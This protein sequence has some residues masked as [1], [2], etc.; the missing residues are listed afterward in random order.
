M[1]RFLVGF[2]AVFGFISLLVTIALGIG[3]WVLAGKLGEL[4]PFDTAG[5][6]PSKNAVVVVDLRSPPLDGPEQDRVTA[7]LADGPQLTLQ[8]TLD[9]IGWAGQDANVAGMALRLS[10]DAMDLA[11]A[12][13]LQRAI[14][15]FR[16][17]GK[18]V[19]AHASSFGEFGPGTISYF[20][21]SAADSIAV[22]E[23][24]S[25]GVTGVYAS[26]PFAADALSLLS[27]RADVGRRGQYKTAPEMATES[28]MGPAHRE[29][30]ES[31]TGDLF[32]QITASIAANRHLD[33]Q[34]LLALIDRAPLSADEA[35]EGGLIDD[36]VAWQ[37]LPRLL[38]PMN[39]AR[40]NLIDLAD[41]HAW[42]AG[43]R[44][45]PD[46]QAAL[47]Y[48]SGTVIEGDADNG[49][50]GAGGQMGA[51]TI[52]SA[53]TEA[54]N[55]DEFAG[56]ILRVDSGGGSASASEVIAKAVEYAAYQGKPLV[57]SMGSVAASG[58]YWLAAPATAIVAEGGTLT[59]SI[60]VFAG[61]IVTGELWER[62]GVNW[63]SVQQG[64]NAGMFSSQQ[65]F[66][67]DERARLNRFLD[68]IY[69]DFIDRVAEGRNLPR[70]QVEQIAQGRV[71]TGA[72]AL[73][74]G[75]VDRIG[76]L[77]TA[78]EELALALNLP[79]GE[80]LAAV[81]FP[82][83]R[84]LFDRALSLARSGSR[85][86]M[87]SRSA[88]PSAAAEL[89]D[90]LNAAAPRGLVQMAPIEVNGRLY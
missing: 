31:L 85:A 42:A 60:G 3:A 41:Y 27:L 83:A 34:D 39:G 30:M 56:I 73:E 87:A 32:A 75:L 79:A 71:W 51:D 53:I 13:A 78:V 14:V 64:D 69:A 57:I 82:E 28:A 29:F 36:V 54:A 11:T 19:V 44:P 63:E 21:A 84:G 89:A 9:A 72:Q 26:V 25:V 10:G 35:L 65:P 86:L 24:G 52:A 45:E 37:D 76:G 55:D 38:A 5:S 48:A 47:I 16:A 8:Q 33:E 49:L 20:I 61:K 66:T 68:S 77:E 59:G 50:F 17:Q 18:P 2:L 81:T 6:E 7:A 62:F 22:Q 23:G 15:G 88:L 90:L 74:R 43:E 4:S 12:Q 58:A 67:A 80:T 1:K 46:R 70:D 40:E